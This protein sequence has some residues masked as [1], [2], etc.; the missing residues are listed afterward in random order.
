MSKEKGLLYSR[1]QEGFSIHSRD[2]CV[3]DF[4]GTVHCIFSF[5][6]RLQRKNFLSFQYKMQEW[7]GLELFCSMEKNA[8][9]QGRATV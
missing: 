3:L 7:K 4:V 6:C 2:F 8:Y 1:L 5:Y 9:A